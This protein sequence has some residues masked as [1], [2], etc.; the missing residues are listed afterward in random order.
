MICQAAL[1]LAANAF[2]TMGGLTFTAGY[3]QQNAV[4][5][6]NG[7]TATAYPGTSLNCTADC[8]STAW[9]QNSSK[10]GDLKGYV[11]GVRYK[12][13]PAIEVGYG[14]G[15]ADYVS[16]AATSATAQTQYNSS[17]HL[18]GLGY[19]ASPALLLGLNYVVTNLDSS[20]WNA[21]ARYSLSKRT[22]V[23]GQVGLANN[24]KGC[25]AG[26]NNRNW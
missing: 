10:P 2:Y 21:Q 16:G 19:Q 1:H 11:A 15:H 8:S 4:S 6:Y 26:F 13:S 22:M 9:L 20:L 14:F 25:M 5:N 7:T 12:V 3:N 23:Y 24:G 18:I 17:S